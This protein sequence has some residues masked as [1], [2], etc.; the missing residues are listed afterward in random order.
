MAIE[1]TVIVKDDMD[2]SAGASPRLFTIGDRRFR[3]DLTD[4]NMDALE[5]ALA[6]FIDKAM[7]IVTKPSVDLTAVR[8]WAA[9]NGIEVS[10]KG[11]VSAEVL[12]KYAAAQAEGPTEGTES[13]PDPETL[14]DIVIVD[15]DGVAPGKR[16]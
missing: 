9:E 1:R 11:R 15:G 13:I 5:A 8:A 4:A 2:G 10:P 3:I 7:E 6:P 12:A 14:G 16:A